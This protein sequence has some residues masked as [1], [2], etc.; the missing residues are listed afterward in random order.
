MSVSPEPAVETA[1]EAIYQGERDDEQGDTSAD[2]PEVALIAQYG[3]RVLKVHP[4]V[5]R[6]E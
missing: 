5:R 4:K 3:I 2:I 6:E 1:L